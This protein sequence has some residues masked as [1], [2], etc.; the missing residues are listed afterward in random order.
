MR[1]R[2][3]TETVIAKAASLGSVLLPALVAMA[4]ALFF[5]RAD[6]HFGDDAATYVDAAR[7]L[8]SGLGF[9]TSNEDAT[10]PAVLA[11]IVAFHAIKV[12]P[13]AVLG[14]ISVGLIAASVALLLPE[15]KFGRFGRRAD[16]LV[17][18]VSE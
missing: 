2:D 16:A 8:I 18:E 9:A 15:I 4:A 11:P 10:K 3:P 1:Q 12:L 6:I 5:C 13:I 17:E 7:S 14:W